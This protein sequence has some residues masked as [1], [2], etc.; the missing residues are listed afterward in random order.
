MGFDVDLFKNLEFTI[1]LKTLGSFDYQQMKHA[2]NSLTSKKIYPTYNKDEI[3]VFVPFPEV[4]YVRGKGIIKA[5]VYERMVPFLLELKKGFTRYQ[6]QAALN[7]RSTISQRMYELLSRW[8]DTGIW[9][10]VEIIYLKKLLDIEGKYKE[11]SA[12]QRYVLQA[13]QRELSKKT[14]LS[15]DYTLHKTSRQYTHID[16]KIYT[17]TENDQFIEIDKN[18]SD[19]KSMRCLKYLQELG[20]TNKSIQNKIISEKQ[21]QFWRWLHQYKT[22]KDRIQNPAGHLINTL[23]LC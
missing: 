7:L 12:F 4:H 10:G 15:F 19:E 20:V 17:Q 22:R 3:H 14:D 8:K 5:V 6:L 18:L 11:F 2:A 13:S 23:N 9:Q 16:F 1:S 21:D